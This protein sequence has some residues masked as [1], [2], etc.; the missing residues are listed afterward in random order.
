[1]LLGFR[2]EKPIHPR[3]DVKA[4]SLGVQR[5]SGPS[6]YLVQAGAKDTISGCKLLLNCDL[7][8]DP[9][10]RWRGQQARQG[11][12]KEDRKCV[13]ALAVYVSGAR[14]SYSQPA[15]APCYWSQ[16]SNSVL[17]L[18]NEPAGELSIARSPYD[19]EL[20]SKTNSSLAATCDSASGLDRE[21]D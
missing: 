14:L 3:M 20:V 13:E 8:T 15:L 5:R 16:V 19:S 21:L 17:E 11:A 7:F 9:E 4:A 18:S 10:R 6:L 12:H 2:N 1:V